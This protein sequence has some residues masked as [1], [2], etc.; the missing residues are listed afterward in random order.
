MPHLKYIP[1]STTYRIPVPAGQDAGKQWLRLYD[2]VL[3]DP[4]VQRLPPDLFKHW[5]NLLCLAN[6]GT[7]RG[8]LRKRRMWRFACA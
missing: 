7:L 4:E 5:V 2:D 6:K 8:T 3:D 1:S